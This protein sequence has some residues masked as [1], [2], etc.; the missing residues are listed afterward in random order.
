MNKVFS[1][2]G[3]DDVNKFLKGFDAK[4]NKKIMN[5]GLA[6][7]GA[8]LKAEMKSNIGSGRGG[9]YLT[10]NIKI[11]Q[12]K[13]TKRALKWI[14]FKKTSRRTDKQ[15]ER[16]NK[17][18]S[19]RSGHTDRARRSWMEMGAYWLEFGT[20]ERMTIPRANK[21]RSIG[22][23]IART[24]T[25]ERGR[26]APIA[27]FRKAVASKMDPMVSRFSKDMGKAIDAYVMRTFKRVS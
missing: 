8:V 27:W 17:E 6:K 18:L 26:V 4:V 7:T 22:E 2:H 3:M 13:K 21:T 14:G 24:G 15:K 23:A 1:I 25:G 10:R 16:F 9:S 11:W 19:N 12:G 20:M 5:Q